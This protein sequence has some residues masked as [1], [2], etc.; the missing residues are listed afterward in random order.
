MP[1]LL[2]FFHQGNSSKPPYPQPFPPRKRRERESVA[3]R[4]PGQGMRFLRPLKLHSRWHYKIRLM[5][6]RYTRG[7][8]ALRGISHKGQDNTDSTLTRKG[9]LVSCPRK[10]KELAVP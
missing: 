10:L 1:L 2:N 8:G 5:Q 3:Y 7:V 9:G 4:F 6:I